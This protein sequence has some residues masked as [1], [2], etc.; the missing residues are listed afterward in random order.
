MGEV[1]TPSWV[2]NAAVVPARACVGA[3][4]NEG[5]R[6]RGGRPGTRLHSGGFVLHA[7]FSGRRIVELQ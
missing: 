7:S 3:T 1:R 4:A 6:G 5:G 2:W